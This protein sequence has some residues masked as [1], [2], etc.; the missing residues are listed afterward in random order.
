MGRYS[1]GHRFHHP[2]KVRIDTADSYEQNLAEG[3]RHR[4][5]DKRQQQIKAQVN[6]ADEV[7]ATAIVPQDL[8]DEVTAL[9]DYQ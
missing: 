2:D 3:A 6:S 5:F 8:L 1:L 4:W 7:G 9:V